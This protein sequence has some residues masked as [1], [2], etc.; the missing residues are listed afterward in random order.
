MTWSRTRLILVKGL[1]VKQTIQ[2]VLKIEN[3]SDIPNLL[4]W[5]LGDDEEEPV[6]MGGNIIGVTRVID[7]LEIE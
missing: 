2:L 7:I 1:F 6:A 5:G 4:V 3:Q